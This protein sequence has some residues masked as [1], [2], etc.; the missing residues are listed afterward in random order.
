MMEEMKHKDWY[1]LMAGFL[2]AVKLFLE[3]WFDIA[4]S[5]EQL[6]SLVNLMS[7]IVLLVVIPMNTYITQRLKEKREAKKEVL[8]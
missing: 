7:F 8:K 6:N 5:E 3:T 2:G 4:I 1:I